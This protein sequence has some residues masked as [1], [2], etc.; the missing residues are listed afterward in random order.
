MSED[1]QKRGFMYY[2]DN[3]GKAAK[4]LLPFIDVDAIMAENK[5][6]YKELGV[7]PEMGKN[8]IGG[9][10]NPVIHGTG[11]GVGL[12]AKSLLSAFHKRKAIKQLS[13]DILSPEGIQRYI[14]N[15]TENIKN[16][17][18]NLNVERDV[19]SMALKMQRGKNVAKWKSKLKIINEEIDIAKGNMQYLKTPEF[20]DE[21]T[22]IVKHKMKGTPF[23][24]KSLG[25]GTAGQYRSWHGLGS[26][27][28]NPN[29]GEY[30]NLG[31]R[32]WDTSTYPGF[33]GVPRPFKGEINI[34][35]RTAMNSSST[36]PVH[37]MKH[38]VQD[39]LRGYRYSTKKS[40]PVNQ[41]GNPIALAEAK[42][43]DALLGGQEA[44]SRAKYLLKPHE[45]SARL[46]ELRTNPS[47]TSGAYQDLKQIFGSD[48]KVQWAKD[49]LWA[50]S[51]AGLMDYARD[52]K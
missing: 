15:S 43:Q 41:K 35:P 6:R 47:K 42:F 46:T 24:I 37:E 16:V 49:N 20:I 18:W 9:F 39:A 10:L 17:L 48:K 14:N 27:L 31:T 23:S 25:P 11:A 7:D 12:G 51:P 1:A 2:L 45:I 50:I 4:K 13:S 40:I 29:T 28:K 22:N 38:S 44:T 3:P 26:K 8:I 32:A 30:T 19:A 21:Y 36:T 52:N 34:S 33:Q 5:E